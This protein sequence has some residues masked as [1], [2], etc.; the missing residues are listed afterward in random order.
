MHHGSVC[1]ISK[2]D[3]LLKK[4][5]YL[6]IIKIDQINLSVELEVNEWL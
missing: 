1:Q 3:D 5:L 4:Y 6:F 2:V